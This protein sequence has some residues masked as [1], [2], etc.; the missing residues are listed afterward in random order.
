MIG[1]KTFLN[2]RLQYYFEVMS[3]QNNAKNV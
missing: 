3:V 2:Q 1:W